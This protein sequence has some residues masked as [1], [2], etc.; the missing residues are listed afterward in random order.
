MAH[1]IRDFKSGRE[2]AYNADG[3][4]KAQ[5]LVD[6][7]QAGGATT[8]ATTG[9]TDLYVIVPEAGVLVGVDFSGVDALAAHD[10][11]YVTFSIT[12]LSTDGAGSTAMLAAT[13][14]NTSKATGGSAVAANTRRALTLNGTAANL[15]V[16][17]GQRL[18]IRVAAT[19]TLANT[20][21]FSAFSLRIRRSA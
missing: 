17:R 9:N 11:N 3:T 13:D 20:I 8:V 5:G 6:Q 15:V 16:T 4:V 2:I 7:V 14:V 12:N 1:K 10:S 21:T 19:G 18:R